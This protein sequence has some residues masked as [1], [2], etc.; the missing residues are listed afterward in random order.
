MNQSQS[1]AVLIVPLFFLL[2]LLVIP[3]L[4]ALMSGWKLLA[5]RF[6]TQ[7]EFFGQKWSWQSAQMRYR[8]NYNNCLIVGADQAGLF[9]QPMIFFR[10]AHPPLLIPWNEISWHEAQVLWMRF[11]ELRLGRTE[12]VPFRIRASLAARIQ[13]ATGPSWPTPVTA[14]RA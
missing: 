2:L 10:F 13:A 6:R 12:Q 9:I 7:P 14:S 1:L 4:I 8:T 3:N 11:V 5:L